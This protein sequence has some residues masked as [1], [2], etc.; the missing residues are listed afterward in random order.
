MLAKLMK[1]KSLLSIFGVVSLRQ[2]DSLEYPKWISQ[3]EQPSFQ[4]RQASKKP[5]LGILPIISVVL[6]TS[7]PEKFSG[8][9]DKSIASLINQTASNWELVVVGNID[10]E[11]AILRDERIKVLP[12]KNDSNFYVSANKAIQNAQGSLVTFINE[13]DQLSKH[14]VQYLANEIANNSLLKIIVTDED[15]LDESRQRYDP[16]FKPDWNPDYLSNYNYFSKAVVYDKRL[17]IDLG[18]FDH[19]EDDPYHSLS[20]QA[21]LK[22]S[23]LQIGHISEVLFH[24]KRRNEDK[25][26]IGVFQ[27]P[28]PVPL[29]T[30]IIPIKDK[31]KLLKDCLNSLFEHTNY[32]N[33]EII[34]IDNQSEQEKTLEYLDELKGSSNIRI[35]D[36]DKPFNYSE[37][38]NIAVIEA[39]GSLICFLNNDTTIIEDDWLSEMVSHACRPEIGCVGA[40]LLY[41]DGTIQ[42]AGVILGLKGY[43]SH[44]HKGFAANDSGYFNR[45]EVAHNVS[46]VTAACMVVKK[47]IFQ[48]V[49][50][51]DAFNLRVA[52]NDVDLCLKVREKGYR[53][54]FTP[55]AQLIHHESKSRGKKRNKEQQK[56]LQVE[57][58]F[59]REKWGE[60]LN[61]DPA[62]NKNL[63]LLREDFSLGFDR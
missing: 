21:T 8:L 39:K 58:D 3:V 63:T 24:L 6:V 2:D 35:L 27:I 23:D 22:L 17:F 9:I 47:K 42:H 40:K 16:F 51:F 10:N 25:I 46:A 37:M 32:K 45:L 26:S 54:L 20:L 43:A 50:G 29:V 59:L 31:V 38:N 48:E 61:S 14:A 13:G 12:V 36:Y 44:A 53:N 19:E 30:I 41:P 15:L 1:L 60:A 28:Q 33:F 57:A 49:G 56:Q 34:I 11:E 7:S 52:Y 4:N 55:H 18:G 62:Y 5:D